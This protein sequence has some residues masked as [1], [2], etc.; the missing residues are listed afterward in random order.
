MEM[1][2]KKKA[3]RGSQEKYLHSFK[4]KKILFSQRHSHIN[5][6]TTLWDNS[7]PRAHKKGDPQY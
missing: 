2:A 1:E 7:E 5:M 6:G 4:A 3:N